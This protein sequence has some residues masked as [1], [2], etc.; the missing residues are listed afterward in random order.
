M[1]LRIWG[2]LGAL[3]GLFGGRGLKARLFAFCFLRVRC[4]LSSGVLFTV[5]LRILPNRC[6]GL[7]FGMFRV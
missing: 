1:V 4:M 6:F 5:S 3:G 2:F 7:G